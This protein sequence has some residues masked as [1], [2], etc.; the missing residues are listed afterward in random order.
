MVEGENAGSVVES[1]VEEV[2]AEPVAAEPVE[3]PKAPE[4]MSSRDALEAAMAKVKT[5]AVEIAKPEPKAQ[6]GEV[7]KS[8]KYEPP[9]EYTAEEKADF[10]QLSPKGQEAQLRL[11][12][13]RR[14]RLDEIKA[15]AKEHE[16]A[17]KLAESVNPYIKA[18]GLKD[19]PEV[20]LQ[21]AL[22]MWKE[23][24]DPKTPEEIKAAAA[25]YL[26]AR[27]VEVP[28]GFLT[29]PENNAI[30]STIA[31]L[32][33]EIEA[34]KLR[35]SEADQAKKVEIL[36]TAW[37]SFEK[38]TNAAGKLKF[39]DINNTESGLK[40]SSEIGSLVSGDNALSKDFI[41]RAQ[42]RIPGLTYQ[43]L[44]KEAY[45]YLGGKVDESATAITRPEPAQPSH[46]LKSKRAASSI[47]GRG[48]NSS[49]SGPSKKF[50]SYREAAQAALAE[51]N[52]EEH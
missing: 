34:L 26:Q 36:N 1:K 41:A 27:G 8:P 37:M 4:K 51:L 33:K 3:T 10:L 31:P 14:S 22:G 39:P 45:R 15:A 38:E 7:Q 30:A 32:Q 48:G 40:L 19:S 43:E 9:A 23:F 5:P 49:V 16:H 2:I 24:E 29:Q 25:K 28:E 12:K 11:D 47:P 35:Q 50:K 42:A 46:L 17:K 21:K 44:F 13:S 6:T 18:M 20:A 52:N